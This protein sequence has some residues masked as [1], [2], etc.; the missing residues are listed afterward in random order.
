MTFNGKE[1]SDM[2]AKEISHVL[3]A[4]TD[5]LTPEQRSWFKYL[6]D[7]RKEWEWMQTD[8][9][10][11]RNDFSGRAGNFWFGSVFGN[12]PFRLKI[13]LDKS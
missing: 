5:K 12:F 13:R 11:H 2:T 7:A 10:K 9:Y 6:W 8:E 3:V 4:D 1:L